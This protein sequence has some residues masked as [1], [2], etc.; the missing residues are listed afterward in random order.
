MQRLYETM[1]AGFKGIHDRLDAQNGRVGK[2]EVADAELRQ[3]M[4]SLEK[5]VF[6]QPRR[7]FTD[8]ES[9]RK[10]RLTKREGTLIA[11]GLGVLATFFKLCLLLGDAAVEAFKAAVR[12]K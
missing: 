2:G 9:E 3:R 8:V 12:V 5:E 6:S 4:T 7:R 1:D 10:S 11:L